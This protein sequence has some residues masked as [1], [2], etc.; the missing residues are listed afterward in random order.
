MAPG[1]LIQ[2]NEKLD[3]SCSTLLDLNLYVCCLMS[4]YC[5]NAVGTGVN[6]LLL[7]IVEHE[8][9]CKTCDNCKEVFLR[10][11]VHTVTLADV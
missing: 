5:G 10:V 4:V 8:L 6:V 11:L 2:K 7:W 9:Y 1:A 3:I